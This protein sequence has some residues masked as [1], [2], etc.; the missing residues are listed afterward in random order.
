MVK[1][2]EHLLTFCFI[3][4]C[5]SAHPPARP[6]DHPVSLSLNRMPLDPTMTPPSNTPVST[7][8]D[9]PGG[10]PLQD[11]VFSGP[12]QNPTSEDEPMLQPYP[13]GSI[14]LDD[15]MPLDN[16]SLGDTTIHDISSPPR[17]PASEDQPMPQTYPHD[18]DELMPPA[19]TTLH[20]IP[21]P[22]PEF[23]ESRKEFFVVYPH[24]SRSLFDP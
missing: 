16:P 6:N 14:Q 2:S 20:S 4:I 13:H 17:D 3:Y 19:D 12:S 21:Q 18:L 1:S 23:S 8:T 22:P 11:L 7:G 24:L 10:V 9:R 15:P 5:S